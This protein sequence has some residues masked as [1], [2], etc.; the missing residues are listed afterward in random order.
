M[1]RRDMS[2]RPSATLLRIVRRRTEQ[3]RDELAVIGID[4]FAFR[5]GQRYGTIGCDLERRRPVTLL[6]D[7]EQATSEA[8]LSDHP[9]IMTVARDRGDGCG[10][11]IVKALPHADQV[12]DRCI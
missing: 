9:S 11:A 12:A 5:R 7:R 2:W 4:N 8:W 1:I 3:P 10:E 6:P